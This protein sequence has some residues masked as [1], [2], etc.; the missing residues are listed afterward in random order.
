MMSALL[1]LQ[2]SILIMANDAADLDE[3][4]NV[5]PVLDF[6]FIRL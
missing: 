1:K 4:V 3:R 2:L 6:D 5:R